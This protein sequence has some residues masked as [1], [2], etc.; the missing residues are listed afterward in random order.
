M[1]DKERLVQLI[2]KQAFKCSDTPTFRLA[3]GV[4]SKYY[5]NMK[6]VNYTPEGQYLVGK[7]LYEKI[8]ELSISPKAAGGL[9]LGAD[10]IA[11]ALA[12]YSFDMRDP[13][14]AF[15]VRK[16]PK[17]HGLGRQVEGN[18]KSGDRVI[19][20]EDVITT[21]GSSI[22]AIEAAERHGLKILAIIALLDR[23]EEGGRVKIESLG[24]PFYSLLTIDDIL[25]Q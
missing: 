15:V 20:V 1:T 8:G 24:H 7:L 11:M 25:E 4:M 16:E 12:R 18:V 19:I 17:G 5:F 23:C 6:Q 2:R 10:P 3:S 14:E 22:K 13:M 21:G 9:T